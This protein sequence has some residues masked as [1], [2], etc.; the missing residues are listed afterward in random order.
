[1]THASF[2]GG[3]TWFGA[4]QPFPQVKYCPATQMVAGSGTCPSQI[5]TNPEVMDGGGDPAL[6]FDRDGVAYYAEINF[7]RIGC[8]SGVFVF[9]SYNGGQ[10]WSRPLYGPASVGDSKLNG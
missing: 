3:A 6:A 4:M 9:R 7:H 10:T 8:I 5:Q 1:G 2:D